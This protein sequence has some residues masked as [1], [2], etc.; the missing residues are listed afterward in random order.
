MTLCLR[1]YQSDMADFAVR[2]PRCALLARMGAGKTVAALSALDWLSLAE[3]VFPVLVMGPLRV[4]RSVWPEEARL[5]AP[6]LRVSTIV[7][8][9]EERRAALAR[10]AD[11]YTVNYEQ[12]PWLVEELGGRWPFRAVIP[13]ESTR[14]KSFRIKQG[15][16]RAAALAKVAHRASRWIN[17]TGTVSPNGLQDLWGQ[18]WFLDEGRRL[19][20]TFSDFEDRWF[21]MKRDGYGLEPLAHAQA[22]IEERIAD[23]SYVFDPRVYFG[24]EEPIVTRVK[25]ELPPKARGLYRE[26]EKRMYMEIEGNPIEAF[27][28]ASRT[29][30]CLQLANGAAYIDEAATQWSPVHDEKLAALESIVNEAAGAP[31]LVAY[32]FKS[33]LVRLRERFKQGRVLDAKPQT[34]T[35]WNEGRIPLMFLHP[36]SAGHGLSLQHGGNIIA[37]YGLWW[38][39][40]QHEQVIE[41]IG[42]VRQAQSGYDRPTYVYYI[43]AENTVDE[44]VLERLATKAG[45]Q[46]TLMKALKERQG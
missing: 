4:A 39:L 7:G 12:L 5:W 46:E 23:L 20:L 32:H 18:Y 21:R 44:A 8:D 37:F 27:N 22:E 42:P 25:V 13:D 10:P 34:I 1:P 24:V 14:L 36:A 33:D 15:G 19:G 2:T 43:V 40:E 29:I 38:D 11:I 9:V 30:K 17:L 31:V 26:M 3:D 28:A 6:H 45:V 41:R 16:V 35:D